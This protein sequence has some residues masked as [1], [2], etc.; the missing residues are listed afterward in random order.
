M[1]YLGIS[2]ALQPIG[3]SLEIGDV[4]SETGMYRVFSNGSQTGFRTSP[5]FSQTNIGGMME[6]GKVAG[7]PL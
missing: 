6:G 7:F 1:L 2:F 5:P 4:G 3:Y